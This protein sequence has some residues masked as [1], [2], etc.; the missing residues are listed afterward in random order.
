MKNDLKQIAT[1]VKSS[2][3]LCRWYPIV[4]PKGTLIGPNKDYNRDLIRI[5]S[6]IGINKDYYRGAKLPR[7]DL[8]S[9]KSLFASNLFFFIQLFFPDKVQGSS[10]VKKTESSESGTEK[11]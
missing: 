2:F 1:W 3:G 8:N 7:R 9:P 10:C 11:K 5:T 4:I 6:T